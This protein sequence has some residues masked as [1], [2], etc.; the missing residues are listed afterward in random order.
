MSTGF[1]H[2]SVKKLTVIKNSV[3]SHSKCVSESRVD[4]QKIKFK[5]M[6]IELPDECSHADRRRLRRS[7]ASERRSGLES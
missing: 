1:D 5:L 7:Y 4:C 6:A 3:N 2:C